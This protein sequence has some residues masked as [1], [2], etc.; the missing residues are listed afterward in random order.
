LSQSEALLEGLRR[1]DEAAFEAIFHTYYGRV[2]A[3]AYR[4]LGSAQEAEDVAQET[5]L[6]LYLHPLPRGRNHNLL[7]WLMR[8]ATNLGYNA[9]RSRRRRQEKEERPATDARPEPNPAEQAIQADTTRRVREVLASLPER[10]VQLLLLRHAGF[11]Y[12]ELATTLG[13]A[14]ESVG[15]LLARAERAFQQRYVELEEK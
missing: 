10:Q 8:V 15:T 13:V 4:L 3:L 2:F 1:G 11:S 7:G 12:G 14:P 6:R 5:F 9:A